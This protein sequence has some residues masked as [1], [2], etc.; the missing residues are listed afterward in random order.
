MATLHY[1]AIVIGAGQGGS[2]AKHLAEAGRRTALIERRWLGGSCINWGC[3]PTKTMISSAR[4]AHL[5]HRAADFGVI[6]PQPQVNFIQI[7]HRKRQR[8]EDFRASYQKSVEHVSNLDIICGEANFC[9][10][11][12]LQV[13]LQNGDSQKLQA[14]TIVIATGS[15]PQ[16]P[17]I[18]GFAQSGYLT[19]ETLMEMDAVPK[20]LVILGGGNIAVEFAQMFRRFGAQVTILQKDAQLLTKED[21]DVAHELSDILQGEGIEILLHCKTTKIEKHKKTLLITAQTK[22]GEQQIK[23]THLLLAAGHIPNTKTLTLKKTGVLTD[24]KSYVC[25]NDS[26]ETN[27]P[28]IYAMG[29]VKGGPAF[30][31]I[32]YDDTRILRANLLERVEKT[33][34]DRIVP[35]VVFTD[36]QLGRVGMTEKAAKKAGIKIRIAKMP[37]SET[38]RG[39]ETGETQ[40]LLKV[41]VNTD[42]DQILGGAILSPEGGEVMAVL[43]MAMRAK[44]PYSALRDGIFAHP[45]MT[46]SFNTLFLKM[47]QKK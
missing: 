34:K 8:V 43:Q 29:D 28:G 11:K 30:T 7:R 23:G 21:A 9:D 27:V 32:A 41:V 37:L 46:E 16:I 17:A 44:L 4:V 35:Y 20:H 36:P 2:L 3:T 24:K 26:L 13:Q 14:E 33:I 22:T 25:V 10:A 45:T 31:H 12:T 1:D 18:P 47:D 6:T 38:A 19:P 5:V 15:C 40:G 39:L 42:N